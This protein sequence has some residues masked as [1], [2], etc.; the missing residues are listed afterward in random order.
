MKLQ[1]NFKQSQNTV[2]IKNQEIERLKAKTN[3]LEDDFEKSQTEKKLAKEDMDRCKSKGIQIC[4][5]V[6][7]A[8]C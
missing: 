5:I 6:L 1:N 8:Q 3:K 7:L 4:L 2:A